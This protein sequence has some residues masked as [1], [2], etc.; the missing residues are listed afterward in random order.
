VNDT[1]AAR[2]DLSDNGNETE[3]MEFADLDEPTDE[4]VNPDHGDK[5]GAVKFSHNGRYILPDPETGKEKQWTRASTIAHTI[6]DTYHLDKWRD[7]MIA[8]GMGLR[9]DLASLAGQY[10]VTEHKTEL[11]KIAD[12]AMD[13][14]GANQGANLGTALHGYAERLDGGEDVFRQRMHKSTRRTLELYQEVKTKQGIRILPRYTERVV[15]NKEYGIV[16]RLDRIAEVATHPLPVIADLKSQKMFYSYMEVAIQLAIYSRGDCMWN[17]D[18]CE[19]EE[20][21][22][23]DTENAFVIHIPAQRESGQEACEIH[24]IDLVEGWTYVR[25]AMNVRKARKRGKNAG[26]A[27]GNELYWRQ[28]LASANRVEDLSAVFR[29]AHKAGEWND[30]LSAFGKAIQTQIERG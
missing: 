10:D 16:G 3:E 1:D 28:R 18:T 6:S 19:W 8:R 14:A 23:M 15:L 11:Q 29:E 30:H 9:P 5:P 4:F 13:T 22:E 2:I 21:P 26:R 27:L 20:M 17:E 12:Q 25:L 24:W 7:R